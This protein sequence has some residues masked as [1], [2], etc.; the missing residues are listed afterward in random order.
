VYQVL[1]QSKMLLQWQTV[2]VEILMSLRQ[3][4][5]EELAEVH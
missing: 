3:L 5:E 1:L 4:Q 2:Q